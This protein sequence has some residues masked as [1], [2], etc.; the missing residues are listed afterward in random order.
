MLS[1]N[2]AFPATLL[3]ALLAHLWPSSFQFSAYQPH[4]LLLVMIFWLSRAPKR[5]G[6]VCAAALGL[7]ADLLYGGALGQQLLSFAVLGYLLLSLQRVLLSPTLLQQAVIV[8]L[9]VALANL[10]LLGWA[11]FDGVLGAVTPALLS[12][13][14]SGLIWPLLGRLLDTFYDSG[15][16]R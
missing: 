8:A 9:L 10:W 3:L 12:A 5:C 1:F 16:I 11:R 7:L 14:L 4:Y 15:E 13:L 6:L 2:V